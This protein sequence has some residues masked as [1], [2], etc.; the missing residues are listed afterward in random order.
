ML[1]RNLRDALSKSRPISKQN[2]RNIEQ[3]Q[4]EQCFNS[5]RGGIL[6]APN[7]QSLKH[8][9]LTMKSKVACS[10]HEV[11]LKSFFLGPQAENAGWVA[12]SVI[13]IFERWFDWRR[14]L[15]HEDGHAIS[16]ADQNLPEFIA[17]RE[18]LERELKALMTR[19][20]DEVPKFS[21]RYIG[22]MLSEISLPAL[23]G[24]IITLLHNPNNISGESAKV[25]TAIEDEVVKMLLEMIGFDPNHGA[26]HF[27][28]GGTVANFEAI[29][30][31]RS[32]M[33]RWL[34]AG[35]LARSHGEDIK[36]VE[37]A[38]MGWDRFDRIVARYGEAALKTVPDLDDNPFA[39]AVEISHAFGCDFEGPVMLV[40]Q[41]KHYSWPKGSW[42]LGLG[43]SGCIP[44]NLD[45]HGKMCVKDLNQ[46]IESAIEN[47]RPIM[48]VVSVAGT[49]E[50]GA[51]D[52]VD[53]VAETL[54]Q[55]KKRGIDIWHHIDGAYGAF[56]ASLGSHTEET[57]GS[58]AAK[59]FKAMP[60]SDSLTLD[61][62]K[63][64]YVPYASGTFLCRTYRDYA[65]VPHRPAYVQMDIRSDRGPYTI[66][67]SRSAAGA[68]AT[69]L[70]GKTVGFNEEGYGRILGRTVTVKKK[71]ERALK[72]SGLEVWL[73]PHTETN[74]LCFTVAS[75]GEALSSS[76][77]RTHALIEKFAPTAG[78]SFMI[79]QTALQFANYGEYAAEFCRQWQ[80]VQDANQIVCARLCLMNP[81]FDSKEFN[82]DYADEF[83]KSLQRTLAVHGS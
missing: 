67:G 77:S 5:Q 32:R 51:I 4:N 68:V 33:F 20:E 53:E 36:L 76:N 2:R 45:R 56:F 75:K 18:N 1:T 9:D 60:L 17:R 26:G 64:G 54:A 25:G 35:L 57:L 55:W 22:H 49:T 40:P 29:Y 73:A 34:Q 10:P 44:V 7:K 74:V 37:A 65:L 66:E 47:G 21:P 11:A 58:K 59:A 43:K 46:K 27:T 14:R 12:T 78:G 48:M 83:I 41:S 72:E 42:L 63:L 23:F 79:S 52:P 24:H 70:T 39:A 81:F 62:H 71:L 16:H 6:R 69:W 13:S 30:R 61:P 19:F 82:V 80:P 31:A 28:S 3:D 38:G 15:Y 8:T 50:L